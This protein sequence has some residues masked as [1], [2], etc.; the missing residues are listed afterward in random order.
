MPLTELI[1]APLPAPIAA[2]IVCDVLAGLTE[3]HGGLCPANVLVG[4]DGIARVAKATG[5]LAYRAPEQISKKP[6]DSRADLFAAGVILHELVSGRPLFAG[7][8]EGDLVLAI[9]F[10]DIPEIEGLDAVLGR[11]LARDRE[12]RF[13]SAGEMRAA[14]EA[15]CAS[16]S[17]VAEWVKAQLPPPAPRAKRR[18]PWLVVAG[19]ALT[20]VWLAMRPREEAPPPVSLTSADT[21]H[22]P[23]ADAG[24]AH[25][26]LRNE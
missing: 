8:D 4:V 19:A 25:D 3:L 26:L 5:P 7:R 1:A 22:S 11:A 18:W 15:T 6:L 17:E 9:L 13:G 20:I 16:S 2:R 24:S 23:S 14:L 10:G 12:D 21:V